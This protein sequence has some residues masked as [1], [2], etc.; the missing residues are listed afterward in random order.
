MNRFPVPTNDD[1]FTGDHSFTRD[2]DLLRLAAESD[3]IEQ[4]INFMRPGTDEDHLVDEEWYR[5]RGDAVLMAEYYAK[6]QPHVDP[7]FFYWLSR[8]QIGQPMT[9]QEIRNNRR[10]ERLKK[11]MEEKKAMRKKSKK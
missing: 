1:E 3:R 7:A 4:G 8:Q 2:S 10:A 6:K 11:K 9:N 5:V